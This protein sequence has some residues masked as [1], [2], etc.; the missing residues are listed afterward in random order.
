MSFEGVEFY[1]LCLVFEGDGSSLWGDSKGEFKI[2]SG[3]IRYDNNNGF[4]SLNL[5]GPETKWFHYTDK[6]IEKDFMTKL[7]PV[8][9]K[10]LGV[11]VTKLTWSEQG[12][13][14]E[15][16]WNLDVKYMKDNK[17]ESS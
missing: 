1:K 5:Y 16:G 9:S 7:S 8:L 15:D 14:P 11:N 3:D 10:E 17:N 6:G 2:D 13:Q 12:L 4:C